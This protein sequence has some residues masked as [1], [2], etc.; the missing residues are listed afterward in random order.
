MSKLAILGKFVQAIEDRKRYTFDYSHW[1]DQGEVLVSCTSEVSPDTAVPLVV[2]SLINNDTVAT[3][4]V[5]GGTH[6]STYLV[7]IEAIT[8]AGQ[9]IR[10]A[11]Q[12]KTLDYTP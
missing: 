11:I 10:Q 3:W 7:I 5:S 6:L 4:Y 8:S 12:V 9:R 1:L 2:E